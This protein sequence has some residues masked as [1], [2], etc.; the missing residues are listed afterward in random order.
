MHIS[1]PTNHSAAS[2]KTQTQSLCGRNRESSRI[3]SQ[4]GP[5]GDGPGTSRGVR[6]LHG[7]SGSSRYSQLG[8][9]QT[10][11]ASGLKPREHPLLWRPSADTQRTVLSI[12]PSPH[13]DEHWG[14]GGGGGGGGGRGRRR[15]RRRRKRRRS[16]K[17][18]EGQEEEEEN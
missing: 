11:V 5:D 13:V 8:A 4:R 6:Y 7:G 15:R 16:R 9:L 10:Y 1:E 12:T 18:M 14:G 3:R 17:R 2:R